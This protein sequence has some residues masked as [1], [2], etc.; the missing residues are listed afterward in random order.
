MPRF[1]RANKDA[2]II[3]DTGCVPSIGINYKFD[4]KGN[5]LTLSTTSLIVVYDETKLRDLI[6]FLLFAANE[7]AS[8]RS[9][10]V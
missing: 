8:K 1:I 4:M 6:D 9:N 2:T 5:T 7:L 10:N 3:T